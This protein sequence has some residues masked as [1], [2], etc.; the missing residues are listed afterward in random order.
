MSFATPLNPQVIETYPRNY[1]TNV[2]TKDSIRI[3]FNIDLDVKSIQ[4]SV[5]VQDE[6]GTKIEGTINYPSKKEDRIKMALKDKPVIIFTPKNPFSSLQ[7][8][9]VTVIGD[10]LS[11]ER[12]LGIRSATKDYMM[13]DY[14]FTFTV[15]NFAALSK[16]L[17]TL[18]Q[19]ETIVPNLANN[20]VEFNWSPVNSANYYQIQISDSRTFNNVLWPD[21]WSSYKA[22]LTVGQTIKPSYP[23]TQDKAYYWR[24]RGVK[25]VKTPQYSPQVPMQ[26]TV[27]A[28]DYS[29]INYEIQLNK[30][31]IVGE[32]IYIKDNDGVLRKTFDYVIDEVN[33]II[34]Y[35]KNITPVIHDING[36]VVPYVI[37]ISFRY[38]KGYELLSV[39]GPW[40]EIFSFYKNISNQGVVAEEDTLP[41]DPPFSFSPES[42]MPSENEGPNLITNTS[43]IDFLPKENQSNVSLRL[44]KIMIEVPGQHSASDINQALS[45]SM[46]GIEEDYNEANMEQLIIASVDVQYNANTNISRIIYNLTP[47]TSSTS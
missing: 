38:L 47:I 43:N 19:D 3:Y 2:S 17:L 28:G 6:N 4:N 21:D 23:F 7:I 30:K 42:G 41:P 11:N 22:F 20:L 1:Q 44:N 15:A 29:T 14:H 5:I 32:D 16:P 33:G 24:V 26:V 36:N 34:Y 12:K 25:E 8:V 37:H 45:I 31:D 40:S 39:E 27:P 18:P 13:G 9:K 10:D 35:R 46:L